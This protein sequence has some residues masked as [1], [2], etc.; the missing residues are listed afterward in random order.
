MIKGNNKGFA[1]TTVLYGLSIMGIM[2]VAI[3]MATMSSIRKGNNDYIQKIEDELNMMS[4]ASTTF[5]A[6]DTPG[7]PIAQE[8][9]VPE[10]GFYQIELW[11][12]QGGT[13]G[14]YGAYT[15]GLIL[16]NEADRLYFY[17]CKQDATGGKA[18]EVRT[19]SG[20]YEGVSSARTRIMVAAGG[21]TG[22]LAS[23]GTLLGYTSNM[24][25]R[26]GN[27]NISGAT[28]DYGLVNASQGLAGYPSYT[29]SGS[30]P[31]T[32][33]YKA[34]VG[35]NG[36]GT[37]YYSSNVSTAG[38]T[39]YISGY[40][41]VKTLGKNEVIFTGA[42]ESYYEDY[43]VEYNELEE[44]TT[45]Q[46]APEATQKKYVFL[47][48]KMYAGVNPGDGKAKIGKVSN[49]TNKMDLK[50]NSL[51]KKAIKKV[52]D[53]VS[54]TS[55]VNIT[56]SVIIEGEIYTKTGTVT[57]GT[58]KCLQY[59]MTEAYVDEIAVWHT[60][61]D[62]QD[63]INH[64]LSVYIDNSWK[65]L[66]KSTGISETESVKGIHISAYQNYTDKPRTG[67]YYIMPVLTEGKVIS[68]A[69]NSDS[70]SEALTS[71]YLAGGSSQKW[72]IE[73]LNNSNE[74]KI[75]ELAR[76]K[77]MSIG[78]MGSSGN[79][80]S[81]DENSEK[82]FIKAFNIFNNYARNESQIWK[83]T[84]IGDGT[85]TITSV[86]PSVPTGA[87]TGNIMVIPNASTEFTN[88]IIIAKNNNTTQRFKLIAIDY[89]DGTIGTAINSVGSSSS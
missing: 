50:K 77:A 88:K 40:A 76:Y 27:I 58:P 73:A 10:T 11:G 20:S 61:L 74:Y 69:N 68:A 84:A 48:G 51:L 19:S 47:D 38:G 75:V 67:T 54:S 33:A 23:G 13:S 34:I 29:T 28:P 9:I 7:N 78:M 70:M 49:S 89:G 42:H 59:D 64:Q 60:G 1:I 21:G 71:S 53:C 22:S 87:N 12:C 55:A 72:K 32:T 83:I 17:V 37:G 30:I 15:S 79:I 56:I 36:G 43:Q 86:A 82:N 4:L 66:L 16:L 14:G 44:I 35:T 57:S 45:Y 3:V 31:Q 18:T 46:P 63:I 24:T 52:K 80:T 26:G 85:Y 41:G 2:L 6:G 25:P 65:D 62:G 5:R 81:T 39:S 8:Y